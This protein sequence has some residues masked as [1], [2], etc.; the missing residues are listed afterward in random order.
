MK[1]EGS[2]NINIDTEKYIK[3]RHDF[4][5]IPEIGYKEFQTYELILQSLKQIPN[6]EKHSKITKVGDTGMYI[7]INGTNESLKS[8]SK[9]IA[10]RADIDALPLTE[11]TGLDYKST[12]DGM[13]H[14][15]GHDGHIAIMIA[16]IDYYLINID[17]VPSNF[18]ARFLFQPAEE[19]KGGAHVMIDGGCLNGVE[20]I[21]GLH[22]ITL[23]K[24]GEI[25]LIEGP[26]MSCFIIFEITITGV[27]GHSS[28]PHKCINPITIGSQ[29]V[30]L[31]NQVTSQQIDSKERSVIT[32][33][34]MQAGQ[35]YNV[36]PEIA[37]I[38]G[39]FRSLSYENTDNIMAKIRQTC[40]GVKVLYNAISVEVKFTTN[41]GDV[42]INAKN[43]TAV[44][45][46]V[47]SKYF[48]VNSDNL[49]LMASED[50]SFYLKIVPGC[51]FM[52]GGGD[53]THDKII[54][55]PYYDFNDK[56]LPIGVEMFVRIVEEKSGAKLI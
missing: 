51:F 31:L 44:V 32:L 11:E 27:G 47:A 55:S 13:M 54:H 15:C 12:H 36:I 42:T 45:N 18:C 9:L 8:E 30:N 29:I 41:M 52:L 1:S 56:S 28:T 16:T 19:G 22:N 38:K 37:T 24:T 4:H 50:F 3:L 14:A 26:I 46:K 2:F 10:L 39:S 49:P 48:K 20:E 33:C 34:C 21:Y 7:D 23:F 25:G 43:P 6:F 17:K 35:T 40:E 5:K 53:E